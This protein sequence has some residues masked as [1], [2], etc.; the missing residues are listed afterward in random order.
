MARRWCL[1]T[2]HCPPPRARAHTGRAPADAQP[3]PSR[4]LGA[5][6]AVKTTE[7]GGPRG[8]DGAQK[9]S[10]RKRHLLGDTTG[11]LLGVVVQS[12]TRQDRD[13]AKRVLGGMDHR[14]PRIHRLWGD[15][16]DAG[17]GATWSPHRAAEM[18]GAQR[19][20]P[21]AAAGHLG[22]PEHRA[23]PAISWIGRPSGSPRSACPRHARDCAACSP[24]GGE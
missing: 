18:G 10:G 21:G 24:G 22:A 17:H 8:D 19:A 12:A 15:H 16:G 4:A 6:Q 1:G 5:R 11:L 2:A 14:F 3:T 23:P 20:A 9:L 13:G 7:R